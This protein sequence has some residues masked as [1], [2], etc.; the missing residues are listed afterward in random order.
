MPQEFLPCPSRWVDIEIVYEVL[1][2]LLL[3]RIPPSS[4]C[5]RLRACMTTNIEVFASCVC[6]CLETTNYLHHIG[7][8]T[9]FLFVKPVR[10]GIWCHSLFACVCACVCVRLETSKYLHPIE[11]DTSYLYVK[12]VRCSIWYVILFLPFLWISC[13]HTFNRQ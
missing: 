7:S 4:M 2:R 10:C 12:P 9:S 11:Y 13:V 8:D 6:V 3:Y 1:S 5:A